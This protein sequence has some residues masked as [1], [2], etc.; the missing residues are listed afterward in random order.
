MTNFKKRAF[1]IFLLSLFCLLILG[2]F[3]DLYPLFKQVIKDS[4]NEQQLVSYIHTYGSKGVLSLI[5]LQALQVM[6]M[7]FPAAAIQ[8][9]AGLCYG[10]LAGSLISLTGYILGNILVFLAVRQFK[11]TFGLFFDKRIKTSTKKNS[12][13][14]FNKIKKL[15]KP[16]LLVFFLY[17]IPG[18]PNGILPYLFAETKITLT[19]Y[20]IS[21]TLASLPS[22]LLMTWLGDSV[23][24]KN[25][26]VMAIIAGGTVL[27]LGISLLFKKQ[28]KEK[29]ETLT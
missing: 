10:I 4:G 29:I 22:T 5:G 26:L 18:I 13:F 1:S 12:F 11:S 17:L 14:D 20:L 23:L 24:K 6:L 3:I 7:F 21:M 25:Y 19:T 27:I 16:Q 2:L 8:V 9:L 28:I 15:K